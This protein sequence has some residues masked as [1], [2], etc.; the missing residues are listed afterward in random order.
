MCHILVSAGKI[1]Y[2]APV[3]AITKLVFFSSS[4]DTHSS[5]EIRIYSTQ[6]ICMII[7]VWQIFLL[8]PHLFRAM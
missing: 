2:P 7:C 5:T 8:P 6:S 4:V 1:Q 3:A